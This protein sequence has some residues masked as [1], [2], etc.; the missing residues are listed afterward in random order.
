ML[1][2]P[3]DPAVAALAPACRARQFPPRAAAVPRGARASHGSSYRREVPSGLG[4]SSA[5]AVG[6]PTR[7][8]LAAV[9]RVRGRQSARLGV[10]AIDVIHHASTA[11]QQVS[12]N[13]TA[14]EWDSGR[15][16]HA[17]P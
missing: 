3:A 7:E 5:A 17:L 14:S 16:L 6:M 1:T 13:V 11:Y 2:R 9:P 10:S 12:L 4:A 15:V 8:R